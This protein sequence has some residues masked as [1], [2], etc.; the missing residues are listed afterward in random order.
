MAEGIP[1]VSRDKTPRP[2]GDKHFVD[3]W[4]SWDIDFATQRI[5]KEYEVTNPW[6]HEGGDAELAADYSLHLFAENKYRLFRPKALSDEGSA[7]APDVTLFE[8]ASHQ[9]LLSF[10]DLP[11]LWLAGGVSGQCPVP[12]TMQ[13][14]DGIDRFSDRGRAE[15][16]KH[17]CV[18]ITVPE[19][20]SKTTVREFWVGP[21]KPYPI[22][23]CRP[24]NG[25]SVNWQID[26][27][28]QE[29]R[30]AYRAGW[31][32]LHRVPSSR[33]DFLSADLLCPANPNQF[34]A[35]ARAI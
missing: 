9:F 3:E 29:R 26:V 28:Y 16:D 19:Q 17:E 8:G 7:L 31:V 22:Y 30:R 33:Q 10:S 21:E 35:A 12:K 32:D 11:L 23:C 4:C 18:I 2:D 34:V 24:R 20:K 15:W 1:D 13:Y 25:D 5:R 14:L 6:Y 27:T